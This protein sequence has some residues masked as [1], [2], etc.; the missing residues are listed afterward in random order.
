MTPGGEPGAPPRVLMV[1]PTLGQRPELLALCLDSITSQGLEG[2]D[3]VVV[4]PDSTDVSTHLG[5]LVA[6]HGGRLVADPR[7]GISGALNAGF[8]AGLDGTAYCAW[9]GD[10][11]LLSPGSLAATTTALD[12]HPEASMVYGWCDYVDEAGTVV[13]SSRAGALASRILAF[14]PNL[15]PQPGSLF[16]Y[17]DVLAVGGLDPDLRFSMDLDLFLRLRTRGRVL[18]LARTVACFRW[19]ADSTT[20]QSAKGSA[21]EA[22]RVRMRYMRPV[23][24]HCYEYLRWPGRWALRLAKLRL[25][26]NL[27]RRGPADPAR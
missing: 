23:A 11:D 17:A 21:E 6:R 13:F 10:D 9:I 22:D 26:H 8:A 1:V 27:R 3:L 4:A 18:G 12:A 25:E 2:L 14:G 7:A 16:R 15:V 19:H 20:V 5:D 24:A